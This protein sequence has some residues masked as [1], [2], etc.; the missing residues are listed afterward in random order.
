MAAPLPWPFC[1][2]IEDGV[3]TNLET[4]RCTTSHVLCDTCCTKELTAGPRAFGSLFC[5]CDQCIK[6]GEGKSWNSNTNASI[7]YTPQS[8]TC[9]V[10]KSLKTES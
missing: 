7:S 4:S 10:V 6:M 1:A 5:Y 3:E 2:K 8:Q 9:F